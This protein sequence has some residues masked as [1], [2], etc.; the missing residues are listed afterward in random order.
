MLI[1][2]KCGVFQGFPFD[3][4][5]KKG[6]APLFDVIFVPAVEGSLGNPY[7]ARSNLLG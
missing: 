3:I 5:V 1:G 6:G 2:G 7:V 4:A